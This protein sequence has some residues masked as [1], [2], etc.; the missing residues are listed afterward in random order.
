VDTS[1]KGGFKLSRMTDRKKMATKLKD[2][3]L[4]LKH[5]RNRVPIKEWWQVLK[6]KL[7]GH[8][9]YYGVSDNSRSIAKINYL[10]L[11]LVFKWVNR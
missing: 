11:K 8:F 7:A 9:R 3:N 6:A 5:I 10:V 4:W 2:M 1:R